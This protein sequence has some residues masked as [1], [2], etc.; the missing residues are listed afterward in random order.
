MITFSIITV[1]F[2]AQNTLPL[3]AESVLSQGYP[4]IEHLIIDGASSDS[5]LRL[6]EEY[7]KK[8]LE[9]FPSRSIIICSEP[10]DGIYHAM[11][12]GLRLASGDYVLF[13]N[14]G[15]SLPDK[16]TLNYLNSVIERH[17]SDHD[18]RPAVVYGDTNIMLQDGNI[19]GPRRLAPPKSL[20]WKSFRHGMLVCHQAFYADA[21]IA[22]TT[23]YDLSLRL[24][25]DVDWCIRIMKEAEKRHWPIIN[26][27]KTIANYLEGGQTSKHHLKSL[28]ERFRVM[29]RHYGLPATL[30]SHL[31]F[32]VRA[33]I[34]LKR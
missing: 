15:D 19:I 2:N 11:N 17:P 6:A 12:K 16:D 33:I 10:D 5:T 27:E 4:N 26:S 18:S 34:K 32:A 29:R 7:R 30:V 9:K 20:S 28:L 31:W 14:A 1:T 22:K 8:S 23:P 3:T 24:S 13:L 25:S 21:S